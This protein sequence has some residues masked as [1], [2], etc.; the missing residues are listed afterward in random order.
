V[1]R[2]PSL[3]GTTKYQKLLLKNLRRV[4]S[5]RSTGMCLGQAV[6]DALSYALKSG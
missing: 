4:V 5:S 1:A 2:E 6:E 3:E